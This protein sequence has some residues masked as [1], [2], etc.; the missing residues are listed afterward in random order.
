MQE[1]FI[2]DD[3]SQVDQSR[4]NIRPVVKVSQAKDISKKC[5]VTSSSG[6]YSHLKV[7]NGNNRDAKSS[8]VQI[9]QNSMANQNSNLGEKKVKCESLKCLYFNARSIV[10]K[11]QELELC[12]SEGKFDIIGITETWL[13]DKILSSELSMN[14]Y[15]FLRKDRNDSVKTRG[16]G[17]ALYIREEINVMERSDLNSELFPES[18]WSN[19]YLEGCKTLVGVCYRPPDSQITNNEALFNLL[20][21]TSQENVVVM[22]DFNYPE[23]NWENFSSVNSSHPFVDCIR[24]NFLEQVV[25]DPTREENFL[26]LILTSESTIVQNLIVGEP[27][28]SSDH[29]TICFN[30]A[31]NRVNVTS[32]SAMYNYFKADYSGMR[33]HAEILH[34]DFIS[35]SEDIEIIWNGFKEKLLNLRDRFVPRQNAKKSKCKWV[36]KEVV[37]CRRAKKKAWNNYIAS[38]RN[39]QKYDEYKSKLR[40]SVKVNNNAKED[41][42]LRLANNV[43][44]DSKSFY[45]YI[46]SKQRCKDKIGSLKDNAGH[47]INDDNSKAN[48]LNDYFVSVFTEEDCSFIPEPTNIFDGNDLLHG[49]SNVELSEEIIL[50]KLTEINVHKCCG[51]DDIHPKL[52]YEL[53]SVIAKPL[54]KLFK[55][56]LDSGMIPQ[57]WRDANVTALFKKGS[58]EKCD[59]YRPISLTSVIGKLLESIVKANMIGHLEKHNLLHDSQHGFRGGKSCLT[60]LLELF[61]TVTKHQDEG[62]PVDLVYLDFAK[63]FDKVPYQRLFKKLQAHGISGKV[64]LWVK[65]W[66]SSRRQRVC[67]N[68]TFSEWKPVISGV[69]QGSVL[70]PILFL[71][72]IND[73]DVGLVSKLSKFAD[74]CKLCKNVQNT[75]DA[76]MLQNDLDKIHEWSETWQMKF[77]LDKCK[78]LHLGYNNNK[79]N[80]NLGNQQLENTDSEKDLGVYVDSSG[81]FSEQCNQAVK[82]AS[83]TL[84]IIRRHITCKSKDIVLKLYKALVRPKLEYCVQ[85][86][87]PYLKRDIDNLEKVQHRATKMIRECRGLNYEDRLKCTGLLTLERRRERGDLIE[88]FKLIKGFDKIDHRKFFQITNNSYTRG[89]KYKIVKARSRLDIRSKFFSQRVVNSWNELPASVVDADSVNSFKNRLD[90]HWAR[91]VA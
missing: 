76:L 52:L 85:A 15:I 13:T 53:R 70:G 63:A 30:L 90:K 27:F 10:N 26:D 8:F 19:L 5:A 47:V 68:K 67:V 87:R 41:F 88:V 81:K 1:F 9:N 7:E 31:V 21:K 24:D 54:T 74:D 84:G 44:N 50:Q 86:W 78:V 66:L 71:I 45:S 65:Q 77:N 80:Y 58:R 23:I 29:Q 69:P 75:R 32:A 37:R 49:L 38:G 34:W 89:H 57:D 25:N 82:A 72:F 43:K 33:D 12:I 20:G 17:V 64:L 4:D 18:I 79:T 42:E 61:E 51:P 22:G 55:L 35:E 48:I 40:Q 3:R 46:R 28:S 16:G 83:S 36:N 56:S 39:R 59:N 62:E 91:F 2:L 73:I 11:L 60:N 14:G 6:S